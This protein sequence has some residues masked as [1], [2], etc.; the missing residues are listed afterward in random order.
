MG[1]GTILIFTHIRLVE[2]SR[3]FIRKF[4]PSGSGME[5]ISVKRSMSR[6]AS[7]GVHIG[8]LQHANAVLDEMSK[9]RN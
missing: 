9:V 7:H 6:K 1:Y 4:T 2:L 5:K 3:Q 8:K